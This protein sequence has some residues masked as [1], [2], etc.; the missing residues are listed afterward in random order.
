M[1][2]N[3]KI[4]L[5]I[6]RQIQSTKRRRMS[7]MMKEMGSHVK[8]SALLDSRKHISRN[9]SARSLRKISTL[10]EEYILKS[11]IENFYVFLVTTVL[12]NQLYFLC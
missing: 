1:T 10:S 6:S 9:L 11:Q 8:D 3:A 4:N 7:R 5:R 2:W 12:E